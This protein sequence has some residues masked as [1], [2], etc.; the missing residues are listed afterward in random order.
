M[1]TVCQSLIL[2][3]D[4]DL[5]LSI[6]RPNSRSARLPPSQ[7]VILRKCLFLLELLREVIR[8]SVFILVSRYLIYSIILFSNISY[9]PSFVMKSVLFRM[10]SIDINILKVRQLRQWEVNLKIL[11]AM[12]CVQYSVLLKDPP[13]E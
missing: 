11:I 2:V 3:A 12:K 8:T 5:Y 13:L 7:T 9:L 1:L 4:G 6:L 10:M